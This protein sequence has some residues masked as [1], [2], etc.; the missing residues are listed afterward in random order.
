MSWNAAFDRAISII[1]QH[2]PQPPT[3]IADLDMRDRFGLTHKLEVE[4]H[5]LQTHKLG[6]THKAETLNRTTGEISKR[7]E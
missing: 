7:P 4:T 6:E 5:N 3:S 2:K 1:Q